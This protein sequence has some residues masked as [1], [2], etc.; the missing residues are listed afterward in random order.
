MGWKAFW[1]CVANV[2]RIVLDV[3][4]VTTLS[5]SICRIKRFS[6]RFRLCMKWWRE[7]CSPAIWPCS[8]M[9]TISLSRYGLH[10]RTICFDS[11]QFKHLVCVRPW[12]SQDIVNCRV[13]EIL[14]PC[15]ISIPLG[16][17]VYEEFCLSASR[18]VPTNV[19][20][21]GIGVYVVSTRSRRP[22]FLC[23]TIL[24]WGVSYSSSTCPA[25]CAC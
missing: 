7:G 15:P 17:F 8:V 20:C 18:I 9:S 14:H 1:K 19:R 5:C 22:V 11:L 12:F 16:P 2:R 10:S 13:V 6:C 3:V 23:G 24:R 21:L 4:C 25:L